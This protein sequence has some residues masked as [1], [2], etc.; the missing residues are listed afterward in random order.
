MTK[1]Y[2]PKPVALELAEVLK[3]HWPDE[4]PE[5]VGI[6]F[7]YAVRH[8]AADKG[9]PNS[10]YRDATVAALT[11]FTDFMIRGTGDILG[12]ALEVGS[13]AETAITKAGEMHK[14]RISRGQRL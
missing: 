14:I 7:G 12:A 5:R 9:L 10:F 13:V 3:K 4:M 6:L 11:E 8:V 2:D 1:P